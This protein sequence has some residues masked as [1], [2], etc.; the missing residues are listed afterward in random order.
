MRKLLFHV[1][2]WF[3]GVVYEAGC[4]LYYLS[5]RL[6]E[7]D[8]ETHLTEP[9]LAEMWYVSEPTTTINRATTVTWTKGA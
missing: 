1:I 3:A 7:A 8:D 5:D 9:E 6:D 2:Q 4:Q